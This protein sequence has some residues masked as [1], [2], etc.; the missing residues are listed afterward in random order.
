MFGEEEYDVVVVGAGASG[1]S[2]AIA[3]GRSGARTLLIDAGPSM[4]G[5]LLSGINILGIRAS[6]GEKIVGGIADDLIG[7]CRD[8]GGFVAE[9]SDFRPLHFVSVDPEYMKFAV[10]A[11]VAEAG[12]EVRLYTFALDVVRSGEWITGIV[13]AN[14]LGQTLI[15]AKTFIDCTGDGDLAAAA[16]AE[17][18]HGDGAGG[19][20]SVT[21]VFRMVGVD[22]PRLLNFMRDNPENFAISEEAFAAIAPSRED[23]IAGLHA[24]GMPKVALAGTGPLLT[25]AIE[26][27]EL[28]ETSIIAIAPIS[29]DRR[30]VSI[31]STKIS[32]INPADT[33]QLSASYAE[34]LAQAQMCTRFLKSRVPGFEQAAFSGL[35][36]RIGIRETRR[37]VGR[38]VLT[39]EDVVTARQRDD[40]IAQGGHPIDVWKPGRG[41]HWQIV[42]GGGH[43]GIPFGCLLP[44][45]IENMMVAGRCFSATREGQ[46]SARVMGTCMAM[47]EAAGTAAGLAAKQNTAK[48]SV[49]TLS[50]ETLRT[51]LIQAGALV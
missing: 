19:Y 34:L 48:A 28:Y 5:E 32:G 26:G 45:G 39:G 40:S 13:V 8:L 12:V 36:P 50:V 6:N 47:G 2:A 21:M 3:S 20:Q 46:A 29:M 37:I 42:D 23:A 9:V 24:Q 31:N 14:K 18:Q 15:R 44:D 41:V 43:Y 17:M 11:V 1:V 35:A 4:G 22:T 38:D 30:E 7:R 10:A 51:A 33:R 25:R 49:A 16:G 27:G